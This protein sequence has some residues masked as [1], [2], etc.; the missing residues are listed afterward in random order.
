LHAII[1]LKIKKKLL[2]NSLIPVETLRLI[3]QSAQNDMELQ[4]GFDGYEKC[5][6]I[7]QLIVNM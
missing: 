3:E 7:S 1:S 2:N 5:S 6:K 4:G